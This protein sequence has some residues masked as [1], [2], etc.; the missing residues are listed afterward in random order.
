MDSEPRAEPTSAGCAAASVAIITLVLMPFI[1]RAL[2]LTGATMMWTGV[3]LLLVAIT[4]GLVGIFGSGT[5]RGADGAGTN[6]D[7]ERGPSFAPMDAVTVLGPIPPE[8]WW[9]PGPEGVGR[10]PRAGDAGVVLDVL[11]ADGET[12]YNV[13]SVDGNGDTV[14]VAELREDELEPRR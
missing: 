3:V 13:E 12:R 4:G 7:G 1:G 9:T 2:D 10:P 14:W 11:R 8:R 5:G 6:G